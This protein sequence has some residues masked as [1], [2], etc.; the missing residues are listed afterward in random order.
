M[1]AYQANGGLQELTLA[2]YS[3]LLD[4]HRNSRFLVSCTCP[5]DQFLEQLTYC[6]WIRASHVN[7]SIFLRLTISNILK[8][9]DPHNVTIQQISRRNY[10]YSQEVLDMIPNPLLIH[11]AHLSWTAFYHCMIMAHPSLLCTN[12]VRTYFPGE[13]ACLARHNMYNNQ[14]IGRS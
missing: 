8:M 7:F 11:A 13:S 3:Q 9:M 1:V 4:F 6:C 14:I 10:T 5:I 2:Q 12:Y